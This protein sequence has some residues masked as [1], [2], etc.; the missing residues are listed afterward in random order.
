MRVSRVLQQAP[1]QGGV[2]QDLEDDEFYLRVLEAAFNTWSNV[3]QLV[4]LLSP[5]LLTTPQKS[6]PK[7]SFT[8]L[9]WVP[10][11]R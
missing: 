5:L 6:I 1:F 9:P 4:T 7:M 10:E 8:P 11:Q 3:K 2:Y